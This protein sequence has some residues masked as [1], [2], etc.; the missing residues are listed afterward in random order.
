MIDMKKIFNLVLLFGAALVAFASCD[1]DLYPNNAI[2][3]NEDENVIQTAE[4]LNSFEN[5]LHIAFRGRQASTFY[6]TDDLMFDAFNAAT[7]FGNNYGPV[8]RTDA[9]FNAGDDDVET[10]W[11]SNYTAITS[12]NIAIAAAQ[13]VDASLAEPAAIMEGE[14]RFYRAF[15]YLY[16]ARHFGKAYNPATAATDPSVPLIT[17]FDM[18]YR[19]DRRSTQAEVYAQIKEDLDAAAELLAG[20]QPE[21][22]KQPYIRPTIDAVNALY[23]RYYLDVHEYAKAAEKAAALVDS[24]L[25][26]LASTDAEFSAEYT[27][28]TGREPIFQMYASQ[29]ESPNGLGYYTQIRTS[30]DFGQVYSPY[31]LPSGKLIDSYD[32]GDKRLANWFSPN[33]TAGRYIYLKGAVNTNAEVLIFTKFQGNTAYVTNGIPSGQNAIKPFRIGEMYLIAAEA[34]LADGDGASSLKY[35]N[36]LQEARGAVPTAATLEN[37]QLE[38]FRETVGEGM[39]GIC[40]KRWG[41]GFTARTAQPAAVADGLVETGNNYA[42]RAFTSKDFYLYTWPIPN[43]ELKINPNL[44]QNEGYTLSK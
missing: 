34:Y 31:Y 30:S 44:A 42:E 37:I 35:L 26:K 11:G 18:S 1:L 20:V 6:Y 23:A 40:L 29:K 17:V 22:G 10:C 16:L 43:Y 3:Y 39:R 15:T 41:I 27:S 28:D 4:D 8:H 32:A 13:K 25:Y 24:G 9:D 7:D 14:A 36:A 12:F 19:P 21:A 5:G 33:G 2:V 38:W